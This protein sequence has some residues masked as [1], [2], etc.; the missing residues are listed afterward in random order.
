VIT[1]N[2][3][4]VEDYRKGEEKALDFLVGQVMKATQGR[5]DAK[6]ARELLEKFLEEYSL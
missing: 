2:Q 5:A 6:K 1:Q 4:A 3:K